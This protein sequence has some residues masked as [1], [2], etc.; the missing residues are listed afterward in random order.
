MECPFPVVASGRLTQVSSGRSRSNATAAGAGG[1]KTSRKA[2]V[3]EACRL[4][5]MPDRVVLVRELNH[6]VKN[7]LQIIVSLMNLQKRIM[8]PERREDLRFIEEHVQ[9]MSVAYRLVYA[10][11]SM[12][13]VSL[14][15]LVT[16]VLSGLRQIAGL[17]EEVLSF[18]APATDAL[19]GLDHAI[20]LALYLA[21]LLPPY[22]DQAIG[23]T[24]MVTITLTVDANLL[25]LSV[26]GTW[27]APVSL[28]V[29]RS[30]LLRAYAAQLKAEMLPASTYGA[31]QL[32]FML[33]RS[34][35]AA[36]TA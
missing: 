29:L 20:A 27:N 6:R 23:Q 21:V 12:I 25:T 36:A 7:N 22:L 17:D 33:E 11:G 18:A 2:Q 13:E 34:D 3:V 14:T 4:A 8:G 26:A 24:G 30:R 31:E 28:D 5:D 10:T 32:R 1:R 19:I 16:E 35:T 15:E 9:S